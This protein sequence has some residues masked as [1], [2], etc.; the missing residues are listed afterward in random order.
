MTQ[1]HELKTWPSYFNE[2]KAGRK[3]FEV[4][5]NDRNFES[6]DVLV[7][8]EFHPGTQEYT[9]RELAFKA[10]YILHGDQFGIEAGTCV[11]ALIPSK[12]ATEAYT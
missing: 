4:R 12:E 3:T 9:G 6:G 8:R 7:L 1:V 2:V 10:G 5:Q 11:I